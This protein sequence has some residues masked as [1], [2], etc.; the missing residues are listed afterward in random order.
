ME[1]Q[2]RTVEFKEE[3][4]LG[5]KLNRSPGD[6]HCHVDS[7]KGQALAVGIQHEDTLLAV[8]GI[9][10]VG[11]KPDVIVGILKE[12]GRPVTVTLE[13][14]LPEGGEVGLD[15]QIWLGPMSDSDEDSSMGSWNAPTQIDVTR[16]KYPQALLDI[17][18]TP[19]DFFP[20]M[21]ADTAMFLPIFG[22]LAK[23]EDMQQTPWSWV[24][25]ERGLR[26]RIDLGYSIETPMGFTI[27]AD[28]QDVQVYR[29]FAA[30]ETAVMDTEM[31]F[32]HME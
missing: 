12:A 19:Q 11:L 16:L 3:G 1:R 5:M 17:D 20:A 26:R 23:L 31:R 13:S 29:W 8:N 27:S 9:K 25:E 4:P 2:V 7:P 14:R 22:K 18:V 32:V 24:P 6:L 10:V 15:Y 21:L 28:V 30:E